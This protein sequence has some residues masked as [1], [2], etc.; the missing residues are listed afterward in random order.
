MKRWIED[1]LAELR[2]C[3][4]GLSFTPLSGDE[5]ASLEAAFGG[6]LPDDYRE[7]AQTYGAASFRQLVQFRLTNPSPI[8]AGVAGR[9]VETAPFAHFYGS[10]A[11]GHALAKRL[12]LFNGRMP[13]TL[14]PIADDGGGN[15]IC[16]G[17]AG[18][19]LG[20]VYYWD[21]DNEWDEDDYEAEHGTDM[22]AEVRFQNVYLVSDSF[23]EFIGRLE[24]TE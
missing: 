20:K 8:F 23:E 4:I 1:R 14:I 12:R 11:G 13:D 6:R 3:P 10:D 7:F 21:H 22:P 18:A 16:L 5:V 2:I 17:V 15:Q 9:R 19:Q 24:A